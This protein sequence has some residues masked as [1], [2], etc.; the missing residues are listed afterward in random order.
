VCRRSCLPT[1][2]M[3]VTLTN[4]EAPHHHVHRKADR[5]ANS[6][7]LGESLA[8][9]LIPD[10]SYTDKTA[11]TVCI[12]DVM[13]A[14]QREEPLPHVVFDS[15]APVERSAS[16]PSAGFQRERPDAEPA[17]DS[18]DRM[19]SLQQ[20]ICELLIKNQELRMSLEFAISADRGE[21][22]DR[23]V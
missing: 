16:T 10:D 1:R 7:N 23:S 14:D 5:R 18:E 3:L 21:Q 9:S 13:A 8:R 6:L 22:D 2:V 17:E 4:S 12:G 20:R 19:G 11:M 15:I